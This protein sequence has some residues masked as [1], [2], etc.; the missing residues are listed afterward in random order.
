ML[1][2]I[3]EFIKL[4]SIT[5]KNGKLNDII[6]LDVEIFANP[7]IQLGDTVDVIHPDLGLSATTHTFVVTR[8]SQEFNGGISTS[9]RLQEI[10]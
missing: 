9:V 6:I 1:H 8:I 10:P 5:L 2:G 7:L 4:N 3:A